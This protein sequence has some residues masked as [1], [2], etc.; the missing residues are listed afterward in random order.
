MTF[1]HVA[2]AVNNIEEAYAFLCAE[3][4]V[5]P[6]TDATFDPEQ[7]VN[8]RLL[9]VGGLPIELVQGGPVADWLRRGCRLYHVCYE[10]DNLDQALEAAAERGCA[11]VSPPKPAALFG[12]RH[13]AFVMNRSLGLVEYLEKG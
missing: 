5:T 13:V 4:P 3:G 9:D 7:N 1:H 10:V 11:L 12:G 6:L 2:M 8:L